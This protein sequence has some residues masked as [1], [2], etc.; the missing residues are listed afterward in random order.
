MAASVRPLPWD[1]WLIKVLGSLWFLIVLLILMGLVLVG[2]TFIWIDDMVGAIRK[3][4]Y[5][6]AFY[7]ILFLLA[8]NLV[9]CTLKRKPYKVWMWGYLCTHSGVL[10]LMVGAGLTYG[11]KE[12]GQMSV[13]EGGT[14]SQYEEE[15]VREIVVRSG[16]AEAKGKSFDVDLN[17]YRGKESGE[18]DNLWIIV[19]TGLVFLAGGGTLAALNMRGKVHG[20]WNYTGIFFFILGGI[21]VLFSRSDPEVLIQTEDG[22]KV[23]VLKYYPHTEFQFPN[24]PNFEESDDPD[25]PENPV[26]RIDFSVDGQQMGG[27]WMSERDDE[28]GNTG[29]LTVLYREA[30][31]EFVGPFL[32]PIGPRGILI[33]RELGGALQVVLDIGADMG[34]TVRVGTADV[35]LREYRQSVRLTA[36]GKVEPGG[37][38]AE[39]PAVLFEVKQDGVTDRYWAFA[40]THVNQTPY[41]V[42]SGKSTAFVAR[43]Q[44]PLALNAAF[45]FKT[46]SNWYYLLTHRT[47]KKESGVYEVGKK[48]A[49]PFMPRKLELT[50]A[51]YVRRP[52]PFPVEKTEME[53]DDPQ[54][55]PAIYVRIE[56]KDSNVSKKGWLLFH[57]RRTFS[58]GGDTVNLTFRPKIKDCYGMDVT[59][60]EFRKID[61]DGSQMA[62]SFES[63]VRIHDKTTG[64]SYEQTIKVNHPLVHAQNWYRDIVLY[65]AAYNDR[66][67]PVR[68]IYQV[69]Y[70][71]GKKVMY[72][73][74]IITIAG[75]IYMFY[76]RRFLIR[77]MQGVPKAQDAPMSGPAQLFWLVLGTAGSLTGFLLMGMTGLEVLGLA[78]ISLGL[79]VP[80]LVGMILLAAAWS[81]SRPGR[82]AQLGQLI[83]CSWLI[84]TAGLT[85]ILIAGAA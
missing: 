17:L 40:R 39:D 43:Y 3:D 64:D 30:S 26:V 27:G 37:E 72:I 33:L 57:E 58:L 21:L 14:E 9:T 56:K 48:L 53:K 10:T 46:E 79:V 74:L 7:I 28:L 24:Y 12:Y 59:L 50:L 2:G 38:F 82:A 55:L 6:V 78:L 66:V 41:K 63:D 11:L 25:D 35:T 54:K 16:R 5:S 60:L 36:D 42:G 62:R 75:A 83:A 4:Y 80:A 85:I 76:L 52:V 71:P 31:L 13:P 69:S 49:Y 68:S 70:D 47:G 19:V 81:K 65:Q 61:H 29:P 8:V 45:F 34:K 77:L 18:G 20:F 1:K 51:K 44:P 84:N 23:Q 73:G 67:T 32:G 22:L 15:D